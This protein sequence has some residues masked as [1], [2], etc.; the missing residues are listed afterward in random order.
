MSV[1]LESVSAKISPED[2]MDRGID[3]KLEEGKQAINGMHACAFRKAQV[4]MV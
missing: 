2:K 4:V 3:I 1:I